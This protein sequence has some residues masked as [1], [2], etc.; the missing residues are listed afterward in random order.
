MPGYTLSLYQQDARALL[1]DN[2]G[3]FLPTTQLNRYINEGRSQAAR[4]TGCI[5]RLLSGLSAYGTSAQ[6][7][8]AVPGAMVPGA[9]PGGTT[10]FNNASANLFQTIPNVEAYSFQGFGNSFLR[11]QYAGTDEI[12]DI[13][14]LAVNWGAG[15]YRPVLNWC[16][17]DEMQAYMRA[18]SV[19]N[20]A[21]PMWWSTQGDGTSQVVYLWPPPVEALEMEWDV[22]ALP[23]ALYSDGDT[24][25]LPSAF[26]E[27]VQFYAAAMAYLSTRP[28][29]AMIMLDSFAD[30]L[31]V[32]RFSSDYGRSTSMYFDSVPP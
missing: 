14:D 17:W 10:G 31:G 18:W 30:R 13:I 24:E 23:K 32:A 2:A 6:P 29:Q 22:I 25:L 26:S 4:R 21:F 15:S 8:F 20:S 5:R 11:A 16:P 12:A 27:A 19:L 9:L 1:R 7:G 3:I 28:A